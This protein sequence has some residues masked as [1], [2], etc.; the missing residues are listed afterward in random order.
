VPLSL[1]LAVGA[2]GRSDHKSLPHAI[3]CGALFP[4]LLMRMIV[5]RDGPRDGARQHVVPHAPPRAVAPDLNP[6]RDLRP[7]CA[8]ARDAGE[9]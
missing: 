8:L 6:R 3:R 2:T 5:H 9:G 1:S 4:T 7:A